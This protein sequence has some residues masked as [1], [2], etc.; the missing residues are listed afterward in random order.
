PTGEDPV[1]A[2]GPGSQAGIKEGDIIVA[3]EGVAID[4]EHPLDAVLSQFAPGQTVSVTLLRGNDRQTVSVMLGT[5]P[6]NL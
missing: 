6:P 3:I 2:N 1:V 5:R 4:T